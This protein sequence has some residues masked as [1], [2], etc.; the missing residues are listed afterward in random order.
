MTRKNLSPK[1]QSTFCNLR[2]LE[3]LRSIVNDVTKNLP[4]EE[5]APVGINLAEHRHIVVILK[6]GTVDDPWFRRL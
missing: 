5:L 1:K 3:I 6:E 4:L 2:H